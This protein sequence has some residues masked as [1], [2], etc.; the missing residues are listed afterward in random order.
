MEDYPFRKP[1]RHK[2]LENRGRYPGRNYHHFLLAKCRGGKDTIQNLLLMRV[3]RHEAWH[4]LFGT[5]T[6]EQAV[7][8]LQRAIQMKKHQRYWQQ[9]AA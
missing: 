2:K 4:K 6:A 5:M 3:E 9:K 8:L 1:N 7:A